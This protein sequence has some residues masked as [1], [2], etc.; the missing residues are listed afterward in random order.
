MFD[1]ILELIENNKNYFCDASRINSYDSVNFTETIRVS[2]NISRRRKIISFVEI[3]T[4]HTL[5]SI[6]I[7][8]A[9]FKTIQFIYTDKETFDQNCKYPIIDS[10]EFSTSS[11][12]SISGDIISVHEKGNEILYYEKEMVPWVVA[13]EEKFLMVPFNMDEDEY[14]QNMLLYD[15]PT[16]SFMQDL[17]K[18]GT[19]SELGTNIQFISV[20]N[21]LSQDTIKFII[22][23]IEEYSKDHVQKISKTTK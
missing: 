13:G 22:S 12:Y 10:V 18:L 14:F 1:W 4:G 15:I 20:R 19:Y 3:K 7:S 2:I 11:K 21:N 5:M 16:Y 9:D 17:K 23:T 6:H 8:D